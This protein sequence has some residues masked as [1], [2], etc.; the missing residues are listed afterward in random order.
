MKAE[1]NVSSWVA[2][3]FSIYW[4]GYLVNYSVCQSDIEVGN[5]N[6]NYKFVLKPRVAVDSM[7]QMRLR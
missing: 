2:V 5:Y 6:F 3:G 7:P 1:N 4:T